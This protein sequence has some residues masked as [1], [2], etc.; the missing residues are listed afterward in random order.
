VVVEEEKVVVVVVVVEVEE[1]EALF[2][3]IV[4]GVDDFALILFV[5]FFK[6]LLDPFPPC[7]CTIVQSKHQRS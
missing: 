4:I 2:I 5:S 6:R 3:L 1:D 7:S